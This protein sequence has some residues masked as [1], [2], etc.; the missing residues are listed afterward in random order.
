VI[1]YAVIE[2]C[3]AADT[4]SPAVQLPNGE[5]QIAVDD[6]SVKVIGGSIPVTRIWMATDQ[7]HGVWQWLF[8]PAWSDLQFTYDVIDNSV[9]A[10]QRAES[11][12]VKNG[13]GVFVYGTTGEKQTFIKQTDSGWRWYD[14]LGN[15]M[16]YDTNGRLLSYGDRNVT[17]AY[18]ARDQ[19]TGRISQILDNRNDAAHPVLTYGYTDDKLTSISDYSG[20][21]VH[22]HYTGNQLTSVT[23]V[24]GNDWIYNYSDGLL[25]S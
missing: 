25:T 21:T 1:L 18:F 12:F 10:I 5:Y 17:I 9:T 16:T 19:D 20:R 6:L 24:L 13:S 23:D 3:S 8:T 22:Y 14:T 4:S 2:I 11:P 7:N 15:W